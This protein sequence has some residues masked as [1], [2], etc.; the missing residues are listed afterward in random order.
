M[1]TLKLKRKPIIDIENEMDYLNKYINEK[2]KMFDNNLKSTTKK[3][4]NLS[5]FSGNLRIISVLKGKKT[6]TLTTEKIVEFQRFIVCFNCLFYI[7][8]GTKH[9][10][11]KPEKIEEF[12]ENSDYHVLYDLDFSNQFDEKTFIIMHTLKK[13]KDM[14]TINDFCICP[15]WILNTPN[16]NYVYTALWSPN[17]VLKFNR[18]ND[19]NYGHYMSKKFDKCSNSKITKFYGPLG[20]GKSTLIY[21]FF[22]TISYVSYLTN[23]YNIDNKEKKK[24]NLCLKELNLGNKIKIKKYEKPFKIKYEVK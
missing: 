21:A 6:I 5:T 16:H 2:K 23:S 10:L 1:E 8:N 22:K 15:E 13:R 3:G 11:I 24:E 12:F 17:R 20:T 14:K 9:F 4:K 19:K 7:E 18:L